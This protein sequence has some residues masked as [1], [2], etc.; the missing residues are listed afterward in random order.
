MTNKFIFELGI[1]LY[2]RIA[3]MVSNPD[4]IEDFEGIRPDELNKVEQVFLKYRDSDTSVLTLYNF[5]SL[6]SLHTGH[7]GV[8][9]AKTEEL[10]DVTES[11][12]YSEL[13]ADEY[14][15]FNI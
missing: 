6:Y 2:S 14:R 12:G 11:F 3:Y 10:L 4:N 1:E 15:L 5:L 13:I 8:Y 7:S 9:K